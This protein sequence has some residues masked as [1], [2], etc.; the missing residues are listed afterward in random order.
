MAT[1]ILALGLVFL[2]EGLV[3]ALA[4]SRIDE[5]LRMLAEM[6][7][8]TRRLIGLLAMTSGGILLWIAGW[9]SS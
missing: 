1:L 3:L 8:E 2:L 7:V 6:P 4:P 5:I 9:V